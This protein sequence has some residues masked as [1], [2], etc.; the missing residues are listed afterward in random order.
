MN[1]VLS[2][3]SVRRTPVSETESSHKRK[4]SAN[5]LPKR[6]NTLTDKDIT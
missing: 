3:V 2:A 6:Y 5:S 4:L 1:A